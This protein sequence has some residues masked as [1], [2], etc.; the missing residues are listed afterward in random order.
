MKPPPFKEAFAEDFFI[1]G[2]DRGMAIAPG[3][4]RH[5][6]STPPIKLHGMALASD[7]EQRLRLL[8]EL[9]GIRQGIWTW[10]AMFPTVLAVAEDVGVHDNCLSVMG[11][12][13][14]SAGAARR[15]R[16]RYAR[17]GPEQAGQEAAVALS[18]R[19]A[20]AADKTAHFPVAE[21]DDWRA[22]PLVID[23]RNLH[24]YYHF[25]T[26]TFPLLTLVGGHGLSGRVVIVTPSATIFD[27]VHD[28]IATWFPEIRDRVDFARGPLDLDRAL[29]A[30]NTRDFWRDFRALAPR[31]GS[32]RVP[33]IHS[34]PRNSFDGPVGDLRSHVLGRIDAAPAPARLYVKRRS[35]RVRRI[36]GEALLEP[37]LA[38]LGFRTIFFEDIS[39]REQALAVSRAE[40]IVSLHGAGLANMLFAPADCLVVELSNLQTLLGRFGDFNP[41]ALAAGVRYQHVFLD[42][43]HPDTAAVPDIPSDGLRGVS[44]GEFEARVIASLIRAKLDAAGHT[45]AMDLCRAANE[46]AEGADDLLTS[47]E[48]ILFHE[49]DWHV[50]RANTFSRIGDKAGALCHLRHAMILAPD[51]LPLLRRVATLAQT[52]DDRQTFLEAI[53]GFMQKDPVKCQEFL[54]RNDYTLI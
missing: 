37:L 49:P 11:K 22:L 42:H 51:R 45:Q 14:L 35:K 46:T 2:I 48:G 16:T 30:F 36:V 32:P 47:H 8:A 28:M 9:D 33:D 52:M 15:V 31:G 5:P 26:E 1:P 3:Q 12:Y 18:D 44:M 53:A 20:A 39:A 54:H 41:L 7:I 10:G 50:W 38:D 13:L 27:F 23:A 24:N 34:V 6:Q 4:D 43:D 17:S 29:V 40:C 25:V 21:G 19:I